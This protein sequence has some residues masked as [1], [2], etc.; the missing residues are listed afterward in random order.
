MAPKVS[1]GII[2]FCKNFI[3]SI[4]YKAKLP[5]WFPSCRPLGWWGCWWCYQTPCWEVSGAP[6]LCQKQFILN[7]KNKQHP[8]KNP[9][10]IL[11]RFY[12]NYLFLF[13]FGFH[14][15][16]LSSKYLMA[17]FHKSFH[18][19]FA[20]FPFGNKNFLQKMSN[21]HIH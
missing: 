18:K 3:H 9:E 11:F 21:S 7:L 12:C 20:K 5:W 14:Q 8:V 15:L 10:I 17:F 6:E 2:D 4:F 19:N 16:Q 13:L 1:Q